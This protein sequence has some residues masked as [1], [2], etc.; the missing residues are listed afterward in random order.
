MYMLNYK[1]TIIILFFVFVF[2]QGFAGAALFSNTDFADRQTQTAGV[3]DAIL[4]FFGFTGEGEQNES[5]KKNDVS[6]ET[7]GSEDFFDSSS[8]VAD[9]DIIVDTFFT[10]DGL[11]NYGTPNFACLPPVKKIGEPSIIFYSCPRL[12]VLSDSS[13]GAEGD[14]GV[15]IRSDLTGMQYVDCKT[16]GT[17]RVQRFECNITEVDP[18]ILEFTI[19]P[20]NPK[21]GD[22]VNFVLKTQDIQNCVVFSK[23]GAFSKQGK[24]FD[25]NYTA[26]SDTDE[27]NVI[28]KDLSGLQIKRVIN[29]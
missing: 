1:L 9:T 4:N 14:S 17:N 8:G 22:I 3:W 21:K 28:C 13:F 11:Q 24:N 16:S 7:F 2:S 23:E 25:F 12:T 29:Y 20:S 27:I 19:A 5:K 26:I 18:Q 6:S 15:A 10:D